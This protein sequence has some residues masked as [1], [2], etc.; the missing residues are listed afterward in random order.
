MKNKLVL[1]IKGIL[2][3]MIVHLLSMANMILYTKGIFGDISSSPSAIRTLCIQMVILVIFAPVYFWI[4]DDARAPWLYT[5]ATFI[6]HWVLTLSV[7]HA[8]E[9]AKSS[10]SLTVSIWEVLIL[11]PFFVCIIPLD[12]LRM[13]W[14]K[15]IAKKKTTSV[16]SDKS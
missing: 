8:F 13:L 2:Y 12:I 16:E 3:A 14:K 1:I 11:T 15:F 10:I 6:T 5:S 4:K 7:S 9:V